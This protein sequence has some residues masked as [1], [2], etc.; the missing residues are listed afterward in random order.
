MAG[1]Q[2]SIGSWVLVRDTCTMRHMV[3]GPDEV[4]FAFGSGTAVFDFLFSADALRRFTFVA[5]QAL[6]EMEAIRANEEARAM[7][8]R[9]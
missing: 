7:A 2:L 9:R 3:N 1:E 6:R 5:L 8:A 4:E